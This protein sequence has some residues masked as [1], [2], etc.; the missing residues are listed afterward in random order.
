MSNRIHSFRV[1]SLVLAVAFILGL[2]GLANAKATPGHQETMLALQETPAATPID[3][4]APV[5]L[6]MGKAATTPLSQDVSHRYFKFAGKANQLVSLAIVKL[7]G[8]LTV[9]SSLIDQAGSEIA[10]FYGLYMTQF[11]LTTK[12]PQDGNYQVYVTYDNPGSGDFAPGEVSVMVS[13][14]TAQAAPTPAK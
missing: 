8:N 2:T 12:L 5:A 7:S 1:L 14:A 6:E 3:V 4:D 13:E 10:N 9:K 11:S